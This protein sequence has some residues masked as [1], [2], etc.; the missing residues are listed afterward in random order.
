MILPWIQSGTTNK[1]AN[2]N[3]ASQSKI[4]NGHVL[5][6]NTWSFVILGGL[7]RYIVTRFE[8]VIRYVE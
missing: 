8:G 3:N 2:T 5:E 7:T 4:T 6:S 1:R